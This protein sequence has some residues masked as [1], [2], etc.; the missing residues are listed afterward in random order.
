[1]CDTSYLLWKKVE[2]RREEPD[3]LDEVQ[4][5]GTD[6][7]S[8]PELEPLTDD[9]VP[10]GTFSSLPISAYVSTLTFA[11]RKTLSAG[12]YGAPSDDALWKWYVRYT[13]SHIHLML[14]L[15]PDVSG[16]S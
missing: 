16:V 4:L 1:L 6:T 2:G 12:K 9:A 13:P 14:M 8:E 7:E 10:E 5:D 3:E 11:G 15:E